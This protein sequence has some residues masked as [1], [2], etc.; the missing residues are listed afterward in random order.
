MALEQL[1]RLVLT[2]SPELRSTYP[3]QRVSRSASP[4][5]VSIHHPMF[6]ENDETRSA[7]FPSISWPSNVPHPH[8][9][10]V[11]REVTLWWSESCNE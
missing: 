11:Q 10:V 8:Y 6:P 7:H 3:N 2:N 9:F 4:I 5:S 1:A